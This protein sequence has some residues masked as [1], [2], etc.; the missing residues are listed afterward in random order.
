MDFIQK[1][2]N[3]KGWLSISAGILLG[4]SY[5][6]V[7]LPFLTIPAFILIFRSVD[8]IVLYISCLPGMEYYRHLLADHGNHG[9][10]HS[11]YPG[12]FGCHDASG[13]AAVL[14][15]EIQHVVR[16]YSPFSIGLLDQF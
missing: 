2:W 10:W 8:L 11:G 4:L 1:L 5:P 3:S 14:F 15:P 6:P 7:P 12:Q 16:T 13:D 9:R